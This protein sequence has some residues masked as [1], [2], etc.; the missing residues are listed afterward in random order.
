MSFQVIML[1]VASTPFSNDWRYLDDF[2]AC[3]FLYA[4]KLQLDKEKRI[5]EECAGKQ[6]N[7]QPQTKKK[8]FE[9]IS[10]P[11]IVSKSDLS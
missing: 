2:W 11:T 5:I 1:I 3:Q 10:L 9:V 8:P 6:K 7:N 4:A